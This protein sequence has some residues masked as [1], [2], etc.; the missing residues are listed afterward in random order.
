MST[1]ASSIRNI[2]SRLPTSNSI[3][4]MTTN[5][6]ETKSNRIYFKKPLSATNILHNYASTNCFN[7]HVKKRTI[8]SNSLHQNKLARPVSKDEKS[9][10]NNNHHHHHHQQN[11]NS[12]DKQS[13]DTTTHS[14]SPPIVF[15]AIAPAPSS[16][17]FNDLTKETNDEQKVYFIDLNV[18]YQEKLS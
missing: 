15:H 11:G 3:S 13:S 1:A 7:N 17:E 6:N 5:G 4:N 10:N 9:N 16:D 8:L 2:K 18:L 14:V 12:S